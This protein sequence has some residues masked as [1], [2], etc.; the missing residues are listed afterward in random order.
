MARRLALVNA[1]KRELA[2][3]KALR[4]ILQPDFDVLINKDDLRYTT[5]KECFLLILG[6]SQDKFTKAEV[7]TLWQ[8]LEDG[9]RM[10]VMLSE[11][12]ETKLGTNI[13]YFLEHYGVAVNPDCVVSS[14][15]VGQPHPKR[16]IISDGVLNREIAREANRAKEKGSE[17]PI[18]TTGKKE[19]VARSLS[20][21]YPFGATLEVQKP[22]VPILSSGKQCTPMQRPIAASVENIK[23][24]GR[25]VVIG[26]YHLFDDEFIKEEQ[27]KILANIIINYL[28]DTTFKL[29][30]LD[31]EEPD[32]LSA[33]TT[34][35]TID[36][37]SRVRSELQESERVPVDYT[38]LFDPT[39]FK[40]DLMN[41]P[42]VLN[43]YRQ[44]SLPHQILA[45]VPPEFEVPL[46]S[47]KFAVFPPQFRELPKPHLELF[48]L[49]E[50]FASERVALAKLTNKC[51]NAEDELESFVQ[52]SGE[53]LGIN[54]LFA[55]AAS[56]KP[57]I[58]E[59]LAQ[60]SGAKGKTGQNEQQRPSARLIL[61]F[62]LRQ[63]L[64]FRCQ[65]QGSEIGKPKF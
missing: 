59:D 26:G 37:S 43:L 14:V 40:F 32:L 19:Q 62:M 51:T 4:Q 27:N 15:Y 1:T 45:L 24:K 56:L 63:I 49:E 64:Q 6:G 41:I 60:K 11:G 9:G 12:G 13:N 34:P 10:L 21:L 58:T 50:E 57:S 35:D 31:S 30:T 53:I 61:E 36:L 25:L 39:L 54:A 23:G 44:M 7:D 16:A 38:S 47:A 2:G 65:N 52:E 20:I 28:K 42:P 3:F 46:P 48:D 8:F 5:L 18:I 22:A 33:V 17:K 55:Q 29:N